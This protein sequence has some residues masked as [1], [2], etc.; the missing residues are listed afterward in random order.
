[1]GEWASIEN[2]I[3]EDLQWEALADVI[4]GR[5]KLS[6]SNHRYSFQRVKLTRDLDIHCYETVD[7]N[8]I[9][10]LSNE[11]KFPVAAF[12]HA[13][14]TYLVPDLLKTTYGGTPAIALFATNA[15]FV[16]STF[17]ILRHVFA[18]EDNDRYKREAYRGTEF[19]PR[20]LAD[21]GL[22]V[23]MKVC[24]ILNRQKTPF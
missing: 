4:R 16:K 21:N 11:F 1:V 23:M 9:V 12:H 20:I 19:A 14:E 10:R 18:D 15:R 2:H 6:M 7:L 5:V 8:N 13:H 17:I 3:P 24:T 22:R